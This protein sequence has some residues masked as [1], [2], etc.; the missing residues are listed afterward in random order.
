[1]T[2][3]MKMRI[4]AFAAVSCFT[5]PTFADADTEGRT[6]ARGELDERR[7]PDR[8]VRRAIV[9][10]SRTGMSHAGNDAHQYSNPLGYT[11]GVVVD[12][13]GKENFVFE[14]GALFRQSDTTVNNGFI[15][16]RFRSQYIS[17]PLS[18]KYYLVD[19]E[20]SSP[21]VK[22]GAMG[23]FL[24][25]DNTVPA[26]GGSQVGAQDWETALMGGIG[27]KLYA[28]PLID[29]VAE[30]DYLRGLDSLFPGTSAYRSDLSLGLG[31]AFNF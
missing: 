25:S 6:E 3:K 15:N 10:G 5:F 16:D 22:V 2:Y 20:Y 28:T 12:L 21:F 14:L 18:A 17:V 30:A 29:I 4:F 9:T 26:A 24:V 7:F 13:A 31:V 1:M 8:F 11:A 27:Y 19:Q 23:S